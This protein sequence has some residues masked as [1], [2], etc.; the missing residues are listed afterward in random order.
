MKKLSRTFFPAM[1]NVGK[2]TEQDDERGEA[3]QN[4]VDEGGM[5][6]A[7]RGPTQ[8]AQA[9]VHSNDD[10]T[11]SMANQH[12]KNSAVSEILAV[13]LIKQHVHKI[14]VIRQRELRCLRTQTTDTIV[15]RLYVNVIG[16]VV[17]CGNMDVYD[18]N[19]KESKRIIFEMQDSEFGK[20]VNCTLWDN[21]AQE[22]STFVNASK[23][24]G[25]VI[26]I[27]QVA[28]IPLW[29]GIP[30]IQNALFGTKLFIND[31]LKDIIDIKKSQLS[32]QTI[33][34]GRDEF[35]V[36]TKRMSV[37]EISEVRKELKCVLL[38]TIKSIQEEEGWYY[39]ACRKCNCKAVPKS[40][41]VD[42]ED[43]DDSDSNDL[44]KQFPRMARDRFSSTGQQDV[45][46]K[47][48]G[49]RQKDGRTY[50]LPTMS[51]VAAIIIGDMDASFDKRDIVVETQS[52]LLQRINTV[53]GARSEVTMREWF[54]FMIQDRPNVQSLLL[55]ARKLFQQFLVDGYT[56]GPDRCTAVVY[57][58]GNEP[59]YEPSVDE[60]KKYYDCRYISA[61]EASWRIFRYD[62]HYRTPSV[63]R[64]PF[65][66]PGEQ[67]IVFEDDD[68]LE[69]VVNRP[70][71]GASMFTAWMERNS[72]NSK[73]RELT[74]VEFPKYY[75]WKSDIRYWMPRKQGMS[76]G[77]IHYV[78]PSLGECYYLRMLLN[79]VKCPASDQDIRTVNVD[80]FTYSD[81]WRYR[82]IHDEVSYDKD[83]LKVEH[84]KLFGSL[85]DEQKSVY[86]NYNICC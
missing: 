11:R 13:Y 10:S 59:N 54:S 60:I 55:Y 82:L 77:R 45:K 23:G 37:H 28:R 50:N 40:S 80:L 70:T 63:E 17:S 27:I 26:L 4:W 61:C 58:G 66:L 41:I 8:L 6:E 64:L 78:P 9:Q 73:A 79:K 69:D 31:N 72:H 49:R 32:C 42:L 15:Q 19:G 56:M 51:E 57:E 21:F 38:G 7:P 22:L 30:T 71:V 74:Y 47:L 53:K 3:H 34:S 33:Y 76:I 62:I 67:N 35:L 65:H 48:I 1:I 20:V 84:D 52:G 12:V 14:L 29:K 81:V 5:S 46:L 44:I 24:D 2:Q 18:C 68:N 16:G 86:E 25:C 83:A 85:N 39:L 36:H 43:S 75:V